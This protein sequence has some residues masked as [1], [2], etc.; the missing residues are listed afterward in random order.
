MTVWYANYF[1]SYRC[2][3]VQQIIYTVRSALLT[4]K[5]RR[6]HLH[7]HTLIQ[8]YQWN[9]SNHK[10]YY[11]IMHIIELEWIFARE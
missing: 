5:H 6:T 2:A 7:S 8:K 4:N 9:R 11:L 3:F 1:I 10:I